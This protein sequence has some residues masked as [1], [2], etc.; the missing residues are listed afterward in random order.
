M[1]V[2]ICNYNV[3]KLNS[4]LQRE[5]NNRRTV[6]LAYTVNVNNC[7]LTY[8]H[9]AGFLIRFLAWTKLAQ[10]KL[11]VSQF[12]F[13][14]SNHV[15]NSNFI[16]FKCQHPVLHEQYWPMLFYCCANVTKVLSYYWAKEHLPAPFGAP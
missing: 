16:V 12:I 5:N 2:W 13:N 3:P 4:C 11:W 7:E 8:V 9:V 14:C 15:K 6:Y 1:W 10:A